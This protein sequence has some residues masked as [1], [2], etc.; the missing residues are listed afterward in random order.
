VL[1][2][3]SKVARTDIQVHILS[4]SFFFM[5]QLCQVD[6]RSRTREDCFFPIV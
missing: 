5:L 6:M 2:M 1:C 3:D 4:Q